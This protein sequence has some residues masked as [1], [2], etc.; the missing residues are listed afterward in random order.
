MIY[1]AYCDGLPLY[2]LRSDELVL[3]APKVKL[4]DNNAGSF[5]FTIAPEHPQ[6][7]RIRKMTSE[8]R[9]LHGQKEI[10][11]GRVT[12]V[13]KDFYNQKTVYCEGELNFLVDSIQRPKEYHNETVRGFLE[14]LIASHNEQVEESKHFT[15][16]QVT[17]TDPNDSI[18]RCTNYETTLQ[19]ISEKLVKTMGGH[20]CIRKVGGVRYIDYLKDYPF[21]SSQ[22]IE[23]SKNLLDYSE[24]TIADFATAVI[25]VGAEVETTISEGTVEGEFVDFDITK[26]VKERLTIKDVNGGK[27]YLF[28]QNAVNSFGWIF[29]KV[30]FTDVTVAE[31][32]K[33][34]GQEYLD[35]IQFDHL[36]LNVSA[37]DLSDLGI[38]VDGIDLSDLVRV[39]S[40]PHGLDKYFPVTEIDISIDAPQNNSLKLG[41]ETTVKSITTSSKTAETTVQEEIEAIPSGSKILQQAQS[42]ATALLTAATHGNVVTTASEQ[43]I[44]DTNDTATARRV[45][46]WNL[47]GLGYSGTGYEGTYLAAITMD[48]QIVGERLVGGSVNADKLSVEYKSS[49]EKSIELAEQNANEYVDS[50]LVSYP[51]KVEV[52]TAIENTADSILIS[53]KEEA[54][55]YTDSQLT[56]Y[57]TKAEIKVKTD[58]I[59]SEVKKKINSSEFSTKITQNAY[60]VRLAWNKNSS[61]IQFESSTLAIYDWSSYKLMSLGA[62]GCYFYRTGTEL[63]MMGTNYLIQNPDCKGIVFD[64]S[65]M[66]GYLAWCAKDTASQ[67]DWTLKLAY[68]NDD[69][70]KNRGLH[71][72]CDTYAYGNLWINDNSK[73]KSYNNSCDLGISSSGKT[74]ISTWSD[75]TIAAFQ[76]ELVDF[77]AHIDMHKWKVKNESD[78][79]VKTNIQDTAIDCLKVLN[80]VDIKEFDWIETGKHDIGIIAQ[81][82]QKVAPELVFTDE[83][84]GHL[85]INTMNLIFYLIKA[86]QQLSPGSYEKAEWTDIPY[87]DKKVFV[88]KMQALQQAQ[89]AENPVE[90]HK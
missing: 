53:A 79:R 36:V 84:D 46:R 75:G 25:P 41:T 52:T 19:A 81:Q 68:Y 26:T 82:L 77:Y 20:I 57:A 15:V 48:G 45:W 86:V 21:I 35:S 31:N 12:E 69:S 28:N 13:E 14:A 50:A 74:I 10:F 4:K 87:L 34:K 30:D 51:T 55:A 42:N 59:E 44:M 23:F 3:L 88:K 24:S 43:L 78:L 38:N 6:Y 17:V 60:Y 1:T 11:F 49:V 16:G 70:V 29:K 39:K 62:N 5:T 90:Y 7:N 85:S 54:V 65:S 8:I 9:V 47:N 61:Y 76:N 32:L 22:V 33:R 64:L 63:G 66:S 67:S 83:V 2:D 40:E 18:Y 56:S 37:I 72:L 58:S 80:S 73:F 71:L 27:D 89:Q